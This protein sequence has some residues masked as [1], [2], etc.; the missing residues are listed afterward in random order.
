MKAEKVM[1]PVAIILIGLTILT[2]SV[3]Q[4]S[5]STMNKAVTNKHLITVPDDPI[6]A[7]I[8]VKTRDSY[9]GT[10][11]DNGNKRTYTKHKETVSFS[12]INDSYYTRQLKTSIGYL[13]FSSPSKKCNHVNCNCSFITGNPIFSIRHY[14]SNTKVVCTKNAGTYCNGGYIITGGTAIV[15]KTV[16]FSGLAK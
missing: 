14:C 4:A 15:S 5:A 16:K 13:K 9:T 10:Y 3:A 8:T 2:C 1:R 12:S 11:T 6:Y 7:V